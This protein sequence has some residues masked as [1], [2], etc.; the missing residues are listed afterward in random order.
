MKKISLIILI[1]TVMGYAQY[2]PEH[3]VAGKIRIAT[4][5]NRLPQ[6][7][8]TTNRLYNQ[9]LYWV[10]Y[11]TNDKP[12]GFYR[13]TKT[14]K[15]TNWSLFAVANPIADKLYTD[16]H[17]NFY[18]YSIIAS[19]AKFTG[20]LTVIGDIDPTSISLSSNVPIYFNATK[21]LKFTNTGFNFNDLLKAK[22]FEITDDT[23]NLGSGIYD[24]YT[25][26]IGIGY[27]TYN[28]HN[29]GI[30]MGNYD[31]NNYTYGIG[32]GYNDCNNNNYG[33]GMGNCDHNN[34]TYGIGM[35]NSDYNNNTYGI[36]MGTYDYNNYN[37]GI[38]MGT[39]DYNNYTYGIGIIIIIIS[40]H[41]YS[42][43]II[44]E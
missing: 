29:Y 26:G 5:Y 43:I 3:M 6:S 23:V 32:M 28:N 16:T 33:I 34:Y 21:R 36:G 24:N 30:G 15:T 38:G 22:Y 41:T 18:P 7:Y 40:P 4:N 31:Y 13:Y 42:I 37:Y 25:Y 10:L 20:K 2:L 39:Y 11:A 1:L 19:N 44:M 8:N 17:T 27:N 14:Y 35:G 12:A 9:D